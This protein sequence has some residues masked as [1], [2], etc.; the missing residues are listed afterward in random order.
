M[1]RHAFDHISFV[2]GLMLAAVAIVFLTAPDESAANLTGWLGGI[3]L[4]GV[5]AGIL[6]GA[7]RRGKSAEPAYP[8]RD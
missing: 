7:A 4:I 6:L 3:A 1:K 8:S 5:G 2:L